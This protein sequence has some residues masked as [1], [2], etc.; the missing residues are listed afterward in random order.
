MFSF[1]QDQGMSFE[2]YTRYLYQYNIHLFL[3][4][5][6]VK[7]EESTIPSQSEEINKQPEENEDNGNDANAGGKAVNEVRQ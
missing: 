7:N 6:E 2:I 5:N 3:G 4:S 1:H